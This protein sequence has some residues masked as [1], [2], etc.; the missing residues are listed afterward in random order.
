MQLPRGIRNNNPGNVERTNERWLGMAADQS[1]DPRFIVFE[2]PEYGLRCLLRLLI[3]YHERHGLETLRQ[4]LNRWAPP[5]GRDQAGETYTQDTSGYVQHVARM[6]GFDPDERLDFLDRFVTVS[7]CRAIVR[8]ENGPP[9][10]YGR[11]TWYDDATYDRAAIMAGFAPTEKPLQN[12]RT[13]GGGALAGAATVAGVIYESARETIHSA[14]EAVSPMTTMFDPS[15]VKY[16]LA[17]VALMGIG[18]AIY[19]RVDDFRKKLR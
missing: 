9:Q 13:I 2:T 12:S 11:D 3:N 8:H 10:R 5:V 17:A 7:V 18:A 4:I 19:A 16:V 6:T 1:A 14:A 15:T